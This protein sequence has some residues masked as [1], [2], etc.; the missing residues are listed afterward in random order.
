MVFQ[1][2]QGGKSLAGL[3]FFDNNFPA[4]SHDFVVIKGMYRVADFMGY[5]VGDVNDAVMNVHVY[6]AEAPGH[7]FWGWSAVD[8]FE[9]NCHDP[10]TD[11]G[12]VADCRQ[13]QLFTPVNQVPG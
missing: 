6:L 9:D 1:P 12:V 10:A 7:P 2:V 13:R 3:S 8:V 5:V 11:G 4:Q